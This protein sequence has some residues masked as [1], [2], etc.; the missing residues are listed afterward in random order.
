MA[1]T[2][3]QMPEPDS[4][5]I[6]QLNDRLRLGLAD[7][8]VALANARTG[9][10]GRVMVTPG[11]A[12]AFAQDQLGKVLE[13]VAQFDDF[14][15]DNNPHGER[16]FGAFEVDGTRMFFKFDYYDLNYQFGSVDPSNARMTRRVLTVMLPMEY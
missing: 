13:A 3:Q 5:T 9:N 6:A 4:A 8:N 15:E 11:V 14:K 7:P 2:A 1:A 12:D 10:L 16:D